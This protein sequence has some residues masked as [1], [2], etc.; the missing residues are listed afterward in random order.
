[1][2]LV[3]PSPFPWTNKGKGPR[4]SVV[5]TDDGVSSSRRILLNVVPGLG[6]VDGGRTGLDAIDVAGG[7]DVSTRL[8]HMSL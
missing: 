8:L 3:V 4:C 7:A 1:M 6:G 5:E 2:A